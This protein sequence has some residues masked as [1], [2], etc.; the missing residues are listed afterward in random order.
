MTVT[1]VET[2]AVTGGVDTHADTHVAA[3][4]IQ[5]RTSSSYASRP[6]YWTSMIS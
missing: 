6:T 2:R 3:E 1:I 5:A 4:R